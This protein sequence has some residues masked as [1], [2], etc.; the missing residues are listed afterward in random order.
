MQQESLGINKIHTIGWESLFWMVVSWAI[1]WMY[2]QVIGFEI[3]ELIQ[4]STEVSD[5]MLLD[6]IYNNAHKAGLFIGGLIGGAGAGTSIAW[7]LRKENII[8][9][10]TSYLLLV[11]GWSVAGG[12]GFL[13][14]TAVWDITIGGVVCG[15]IAGT[16]MAFIFW[17]ENIFRNKLAI[18]VIT[19]SWVLGLTIGWG[20]TSSDFGYIVRFASIWLAAGATMV[21]ILSPYIKVENQNKA[22]AWIVLGWL[23][24]GIISYLVIRQ[25]INYIESITVDDVGGLMAFGLFI[26]LGFGI[27]IL[28]GITITI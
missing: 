20:I 18:N 24:G 3:A 14:Y 27:G 11:M 15:L 26:L 9:R 10:K 12:I 23:I 21:W 25:G 28:V 13:A 8:R 4:N 1:F 22:F 2:S 5:G 6:E 17:K 7:V 16:I 19:L